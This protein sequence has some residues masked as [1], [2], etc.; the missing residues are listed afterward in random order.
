MQTNHIGKAVFEDIF[1]IYINNNTKIQNLPF[2]NCFL[3]FTVHKKCSKY[4]T[5]FYSKM[6]N[7]ICKNQLKTKK[8]KKLNKSFY[9][10][11]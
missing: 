6:H 4:S 11:R 5:F 8:S 2:I 7:A 3:I 9:T 10:R 1:L